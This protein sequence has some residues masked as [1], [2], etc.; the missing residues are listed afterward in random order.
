MVLVFLA[1]LVILNVS[2]E[3]QNFL[4]VRSSPNILFMSG[5]G[6]F[7]EGTSTT[8]PKAS[9]TW[10]EY[11]FV[12]WKIDGQW[13]PGNPITITMNANHEA[14]AI[15]EKSVIGNVVIDTIP[16]MA[17]VN[18][19]G[20]IYLSSELPLSFEWTVNSE[21]VITIQDVYKK[22]PQ[23]R[24][25]FD[26][27]KDNNLSTQ[28]TVTATTERQ[29]FVVL[30]KMQHYLNPISEIGS[31]EVRPAKVGQEELRPAKVCT[32][33]VG[34]AEVGPIE[35]LPVEVDLTKLRPS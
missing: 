22:S 25:K 6:S 29:Q 2:A 17:E 7:D 35:V 18:V 1:P 8:I 30:Y 13:A 33:E 31:V 26:S 4:R 9:E 20:E 16:R 12:G 3:E 14:E 27:W 10:K 23:V 21:H 11:R 34:V 24:Y 19:D 28:R 32:A 15:Y 5:G